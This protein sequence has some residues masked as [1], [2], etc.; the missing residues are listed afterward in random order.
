METAAEA[1]EFLGQNFSF[2]Y[3]ISPK[4]LLYYYSNFL[5]RADI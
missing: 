3:E 5:R 1:E 4:A 2:K